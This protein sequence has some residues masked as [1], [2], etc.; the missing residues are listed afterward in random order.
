MMKHTTNNTTLVN[1]A[2]V[3]SLNTY[4]CNVSATGNLSLNGTPLK[5]SVVGEYHHDTPQLTTRSFESIEVWSI[6]DML[7]ARIH[8]AIARHSL[9]KLACKGNQTAMD[10]LSG[11]NNG[12]V[13]L[14]DLA[15][16]VAMAMI[17]HECDTAIEQGHFNPALLDDIQ[18]RGIFGAVS[19]YM[20]KHQTR[21][22]KKQYVVVDNGTTDGL[23][24]AID[25]TQA[26]SDISDIDKFCAL[27]EVKRV[28][29]A[30]ADRYGKDSNEGKF[31]ALRVN[32]YS[33]KDCERALS[34]SRQN[35]RTIDA[36][37]KKVYFEVINN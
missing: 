9:Y 23:T 36:H 19:S 21:H 28:L 33:L 5:V 24:L 31:L 7:S 2:N 22:A 34:L 26:W 10:I 11:Q 6:E 20:Y 1:P 13:T 16:E 27:Y 3:V 29:V 12:I 35:I 32:G 8:Y 18:M 17:E 30:I 4:N 15:Q 14:D 37:V 25:N